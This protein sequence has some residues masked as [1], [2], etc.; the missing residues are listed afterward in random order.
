MQFDVYR[1]VGVRGGIAPYFIE[2]QHD[3]FGNI[4]TAIVAP[5]LSEEHF[6]TQ[7]RLTPT[8]LVLGQNYLVSVAE[9]FA[10]E[11]K[12]LRP[13]VA[14]VDSLRRQIIGAIDLLFTGV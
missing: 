12:R 4:R 10:I 6:V 2:L 3:Y 13:V 1:N 5:L 14:N 8:V 7:G 9:L 11:R